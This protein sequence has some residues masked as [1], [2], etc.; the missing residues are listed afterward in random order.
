MAVSGECFCLLQIDPNASPVPLSL[1]L[2]TPD[3]L[4]TGKTDTNTRAGIE[5]DSSGRRSAYWSPTLLIQALARKST[6]LRATVLLR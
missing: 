2:L 1:R 4:D 5:F 6:A 3:F